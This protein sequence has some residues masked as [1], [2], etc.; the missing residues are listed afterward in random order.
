[1]LDLD[2]FKGVNDSHGHAEGDRVLVHFAD[3]I[4]AILRAD[5][6]A[7]R[8]G[9]EEFLVLL[10]ACD[11]FRATEVAVR[12]RDELHARPF[13]FSDGTQAPIAF[14]AGVAAAEQGE[15][16]A[17]DGLVARADA[18]LYRAKRTGG[19]RLELG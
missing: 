4:R 9:G 18:A 12:L 8:Y 13:R 7:F 14:S 10:R 1:M 11:A 3:A 16:F 15:C 19:D 6:V 17:S 2:L 5:D